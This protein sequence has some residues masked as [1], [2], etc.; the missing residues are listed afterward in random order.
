MF[1]PKRAECVCIFRALR[2]KLPR[3]IVYRGGTGSFQFGKPGIHISLVC[4]HVSLDELYLAE[5][6]IQLS[7]GG[8]CLSLVA[9]ERLVV[10]VD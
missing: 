9:E 8:L 1:L 5:E 4:V 7:L 10:G 2:I 3:Y 6:F